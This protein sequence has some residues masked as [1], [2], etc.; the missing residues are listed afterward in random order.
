M[1][2]IIVIAGPTASGK[3]SLSIKVCQ[4]L[5]GEVVS[6]DSMQIYKT[7]DIGTAKPSLCERC[8]VPHHMI[9]ICDPWERYSVADYVS[10]A[11][12]I[13]DDIILRG[14][15]PIV[16]GGTGLY[17]DHL[18][19]ETDFEEG[20]TDPS[21]R[22]ELNAIASV[23]GGAYLRTILKEFDPET[24]SRLHD[25][26]IK[27]IIRAIEFYKTSGKTI[28]EHN[29]QNSFDKK[30]YDASFYVLN[31]E[32]RSFLYER[33]NSR[34][35]VMLG[36]GLLNEAENVVRSDWFASSTA[37]QA[38]GYKEFVPYFQDVASLDNCVELLKQHSRNY[39]KRQLTWFRAKKDAV[40]LNIDSK[41]VDPFCKIIAD[42]QGDN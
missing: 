10:E 34:V 40:V 4:E 38:I 41:D 31:S 29:R 30:R 25:N 36:A 27:R 35:D 5:G 19:C 33:I 7:L 15:I 1:K 32:N 3:T 26:D 13:I 39:A 42:W 14:K 24:A 23:Y 9:D 17:I 8:G 37:S 6:A 20:F 16:V 18:I 28:S 21:L 11:T 22:S 2:K 12:K